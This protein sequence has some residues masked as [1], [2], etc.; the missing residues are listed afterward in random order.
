VLRLKP[1]PPATTC[2]L[3]CAE[4][5][6]GPGP[7]LRACAAR[8]LAWATLSLPPTSLGAAAAVALLPPT[9]AASD[10]A[11]CAVSRYGHVA[12]HWLAL[13][14]PAKALSP[15]RELLLGR[16]KRLVVGCE[17][18]AWGSAMPAAVALVLVSPG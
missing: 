11:A 4:A 2:I 12:L 18:S 16:A 3:P 14:A 6:S 1:R 8:K 15:Q 7:F 17:A 5:Y 10:D 13:A 9:L